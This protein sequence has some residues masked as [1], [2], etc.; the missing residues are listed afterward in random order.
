M[1]QYERGNST[2]GSVG[3]PSL[4]CSKLNRRTNRTSWMQDHPRLYLQ[5]TVYVNCRGF[6]DPTY[7]KILLRKSRND[8]KNTNGSQRKTHHGL[9]L[10]FQLI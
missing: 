8:Q 2:E 7:V 3:R 5:A 1:Q 6:K 10:D 9:Q 4:P